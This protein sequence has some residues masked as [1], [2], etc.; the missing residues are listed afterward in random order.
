MSE[1]DAILESGDHPATVESIRD[2]LRA[3]GVEPSA[4][5]LVHSS[6]SALGWVCGGPVAVVDALSFVDTLV[7]PAHSSSNSDPAHWVDPPVPDSWWQT[8]R[9]SMPPHDSGAPTRGMG[10]IPEYFRTLPG[11]RRSDHPACSFAARGTH[12]ARI[13]DGHV[14]DEPLGEGSPLARLY[15]LDALVLLLGVG[16]DRCTSLHLAEHRAAYPGKRFIDEGSAVRRDGKREWV[17]YRALHSDAAGF[18]AVGEA[19][20]ARAHTG[21]VACATAMLMSQR[22]LVDF[23]AAWFE[24]NRSDGQARDAASSS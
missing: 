16:H 1:H 24:E 3:L 9:T 15:D 22:E 11:V 19:F 7:M 10:T 17:T 6:L 4:T 20:G 5:L 18:A 13:V 23:A 12:A 8:I 2:D 14:L 21:K